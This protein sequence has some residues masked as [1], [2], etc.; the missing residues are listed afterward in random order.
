MS[1]N[2]TAGSGAGDMSGNAEVMLAQARAQAHLTAAAAP[3][4]PALVDTMDVGASAAAGGAQQGDGNETDPEDM[5][6]A[7][8]V[9][10]QASYV[11]REHPACA[12]GPVKHPW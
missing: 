1:G 12:R 4:S 9:S 3:S 6:R 10:T 8:S 7:R 2:E 5:V 11:Y